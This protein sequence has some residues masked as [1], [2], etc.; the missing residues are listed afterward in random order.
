MTTCDGTNGDDDRGLTIP[1]LLGFMLVGLGLWAAIVGVIW[2][3][4][5][6]LAR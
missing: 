5:R 2:L 3:L 1:R 4:F 6:A